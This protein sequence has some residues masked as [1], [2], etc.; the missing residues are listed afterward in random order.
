M[1]PDEARARFGAAVIARL[2][3]IGARPHLVPI[4]FVLVGGETIVTPIDHKPKRTMALQRLKNIDANPQVAVLVDH[5]DDDWTKLWWVRA[6]GVARSVAAG[7]E[8]ELRR[9]A[10]IAL[11]SKYTEYAARPPSGALIVIVVQ[12]WT[13]WAASPDAS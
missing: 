4:T 8:A 3:T 5:Y 1:D 7:E 11:A 13:G 9:T 6:D 10:A 2:A 12:R